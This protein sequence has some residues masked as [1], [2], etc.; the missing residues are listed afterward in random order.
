MKNILCI[1]LTIATFQLC[2]SQMADNISS[3]ESLE[4][5]IEYYQNERYSKSINELISIL[6]DSK[7]D[8]I[9]TVHIYLAFNY[10]AIG[11]RAEAIKHF[12]KALSINPKLDLDIYDTTEDIRITFN[13]ARKERA[14]ESAC[15]S[16]FFPGIGQ[17]MKGDDGKGKAIIAASAFTLIGTAL[18]WLVMENK[19]NYYLSLGPDKTSY[20]DQ[21]YNDYNQW[22]K[23]TILGAAAFLGVYFYSF[24]DAIL[25]KTSAPRKE[26]SNSTGLHLDSDGESFCIGYKA[27]L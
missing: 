14:R 8:S 17:M 19:H 15:C 11:D 6:R 21:A 26:G 24:V 1:L 7:K 23:I 25:V 2:S 22:R 10:T 9:V 3:S 13:N 27:G 18:S 16:C 5:A 12:K 4:A 20:M